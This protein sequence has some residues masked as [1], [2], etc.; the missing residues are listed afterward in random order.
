[1][2]CFQFLDGCNS[3]SCPG[4]VFITSAKEH[5]S[6][7]KDVL[8]VICPVP[9]HLNHANERRPPNL[10]VNNIIVISNIDG[11]NLNS[12]HMNRV[13]NGASNMTIDALCLDPPELVVKSINGVFVNDRTIRFFCAND[14]GRISVHDYDVILKKS[15]V[16][17]E[18]LF[19]N[20]GLA[21]KEN[22]DW[23]FDENVGISIDDKSLVGAFILL[24]ATKAG[25][26][27]IYWISVSKLSLASEYLVRGTKS[28]S[29]LKPVLSYEPDKCVAAVFASN[30]TPKNSTPMVHVV[31]SFILDEGALFKDSESMIL[32][33]VKPALCERTYSRAGSVELCSPSA[34]DD[35]GPYTFRFVN[36]FQTDEPNTCGEFVSNEQSRAGVIHYLL[37]KNRFDEAYKYINEEMAQYSCGEMVSTPIHKSLVAL[38]QLRH[39]LSKGDVSSKENVLQ[40]KDCLRRLASGALSGSE[41]GV[42]S[43]AEAAAF[44]LSWPKNLPK[45]SISV[46][47]ICIALSSMSSTIKN[48]AEKMNPSKAIKLE[49]QKKM[50]DD[51]CTAIKALRTVVKVHGS[52]ICFN[53]PYLAVSSTVDLMNALILQ[54]AFRSVECLLKS[55]WGKKLA[56][57]SI[58]SAALQIPLD[59]DPRSFLPW[60][61]DMVIPKLSIGHP[62]LESIRSWACSA[63]DRYDEENILSGIDSSIT[64]LE[65]RIL[66]M[67][68]HVLCNFLEIYSSCAD[69]H[70]VNKITPI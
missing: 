33:S 58:A 10:L 12:P 18:S 48:V 45:G 65:V 19:E 17:I 2:L 9:E 32:F 8:I 38:W 52:K 49:E 24:A 26:T 35:R 44:L 37:A 11:D 54:G 69:D 16:V 13:R 28:I 53:D 27:K 55:E 59:S 5:K 63:A 68:Y 43:L 20:L 31:Q 42:E 15:N 22:G 3:N 21:T 41:Q 60:L 67:M 70:G 29:S 23:A 64:L 7:V 40:A 50:L 46:D 39:I 6:V 57:D 30:R 14:S 1:M 51:R 61:C 47:E 56:P 25:A 66:F 62:L 4:L 36:K 34:S